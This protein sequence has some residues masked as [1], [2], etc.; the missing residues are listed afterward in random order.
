[1][2]DEPPQADEEP[3]AQGD[4]PGSNERQKKHHN[5]LPTI[6]PPSGPFKVRDSLSIIATDEIPPGPFVDKR[7]IEMYRHVTF[8]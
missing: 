3:P 8:R 7:E 2:E 1:M 4:T 5:P 6:Q